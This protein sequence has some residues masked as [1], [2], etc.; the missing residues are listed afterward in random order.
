MVTLKYSS[1]L[2]PLKSKAQPESHVK[3]EF[4]KSPKVGIVLDWVTFLALDFQCI[5]T[6]VVSNCA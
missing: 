5:F 2:S 4:L 6:A 3:S 1:G